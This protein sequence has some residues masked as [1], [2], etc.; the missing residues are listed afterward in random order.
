MGGGNYVEFLKG[1][2]PIFNRK[3]LILDVSAIIEVGTSIAGSW[4]SS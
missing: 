2:Y 4:K 1:Y 3:G